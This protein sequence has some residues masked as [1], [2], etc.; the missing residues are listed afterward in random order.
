M[1]AAWYAARLTHADPKR[2]PKLDDVLINEN[3]H[4]DAPKEQ[5]VGQMI[6]CLKAWTLAYGGKVVEI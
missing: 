2:F 1:T 3:T 5:T 6:E 4:V